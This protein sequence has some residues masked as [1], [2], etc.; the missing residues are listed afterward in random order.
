MII[1]KCRQDY[2]VQ[3]K[4]TVASLKLDDFSIYYA[5]ISDAGAVFH[6]HHACCGPIE[7]LIKVADGG[8]KIRKYCS[9]QI[10]TS[11]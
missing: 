1:D 9:G 10:G 11:A 3:R 6:S 5:A 4:N 2:I 7:L 8:A